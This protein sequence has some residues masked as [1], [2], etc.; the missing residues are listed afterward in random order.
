MNVLSSV[1]RFCERITFVFLA[2]LA[3]A[4]LIQLA[5]RNVFD[6]GHPGLEEIARASHVTLVFLVI[7]E[8]FRQGK[9]IRI[10]LI[11]NAL[12]R[13]VGHYLDAFAALA[14]A[15]F[16]GF[17]LYG[18]FAFMSRNGNVASP[19]LEIPNYLFF[20]GAYIGMTLLLLTAIERLVV[21]L[22][23]TGKGEAA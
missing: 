17:F 3:S 19:A 23:G 8:I 4:I 16:C 2:I 5:L 1:T 10:D 18:E 22:T 14:T 11:V 12:P 7:P 6:Y 13:R 15:V 21:L 9:H 20:A